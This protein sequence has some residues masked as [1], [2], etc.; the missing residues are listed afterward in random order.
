MHFFQGEINTLSETMKNL[1]S[2]LK[3]S[4]H[5][6]ETLLPVILPGTGSKLTLGR[7]K[8]AEIFFNMEKTGKARIMKEETKKKKEEENVNWK[9]NKKKISLFI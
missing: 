5:G 7:E 2:V 1:C 3:A 6:T 8:R 9:K 4:T